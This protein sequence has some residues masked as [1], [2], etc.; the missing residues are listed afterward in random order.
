MFPIDN[1]RL[2]VETP[3]RVL[4]KENIDRQISGQSSATPFMKVSSDH[5]YSI[6]SC[7]KG[8]T[9]DVMETIERNSNSIYKLTSL[10]SKL[11]TKMDK[12]ETQYKPQVLSE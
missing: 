11:N 12:Q 2:A 4:T 6:N 1:L 3:K 7:K 8:V 5:N 9:F 10:V